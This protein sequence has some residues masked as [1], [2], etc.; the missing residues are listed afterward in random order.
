MTIS[1]LRKKKSFII[2]SIILLLAS[3]TFVGCI[4][5]FINEVV[6]IAYDG[7]IY[8]YLVK[9]GS[10][11]AYPDI[12]YEQAF[13]NYFGNPTWRYFNGTQDGP[14][15]DGDG[16][17]DYIRE[18]IDIVEFTGTC[19]YL[20]ETVEA[21]IQFEVD[22]ESETFEAVY[23]S[24]NNVPQANIFLL[25]LISNAFENE[26]L[27]ASA[28]TTT[29]TV[30]NNS[31]YSE[32]NDAY[33]YKNSNKNEFVYSGDGNISGHYTSWG[34]R[35]MSISIFSEYDGDEI[36][37]VF[38]D[39]DDEPYP[40]IQL[41]DGSYKIDDK[42]YPQFLIPYISEDGVTLEWNSEYRNIDYLEMD[43]EYIS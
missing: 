1:T 31:I 32:T 34:G 18:D 15:E 30:N 42:D 37:N 21:R 9:K 28:A 22:L 5:D 40:L 29:T 4:G 25:A 27:T 11:E 24:F 17:P 3:T 10:P 43:E 7:N 19:S 38:I 8:V 39:N 33:D 16:E 13:E 20:D 23:L 35:E 26:E 36:G 2:L 41:S 14:D 12:T 6:D